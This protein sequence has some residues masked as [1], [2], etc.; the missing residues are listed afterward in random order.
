MLWKDKPETSNN[1]YLWK[2]TCDKGTWAAEMNKSKILSKLHTFLLL[3]HIND[4]HLRKLKLNH[5]K[6][7]STTGNKQIN[8]CLS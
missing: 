6:E 1:D 5:K 4:S 3:K 8:L 7:K 2:D